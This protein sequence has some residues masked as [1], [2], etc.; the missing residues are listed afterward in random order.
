MAKVG[1]NIIVIVI[2]EIKVILIDLHRMYI[3]YCIMNGVIIMNYY[4]WSFM[5][6]RH[7]TEYSLIV[8]KY[9]CNTKLNTRERYVICREIRL[10]FQITTSPKPIP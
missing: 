5:Y 8:N 2:A 9:L 3:N 4:T 7:G 10:G 1:L 6:N